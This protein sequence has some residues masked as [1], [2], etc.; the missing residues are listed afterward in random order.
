MADAPAALEFGKLALERA[1]AGAAEDDIT[2][3]VID[4]A[5]TAML[6]GLEENEQI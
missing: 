4:G 6:E 2:L 3:A 5:C 1:L